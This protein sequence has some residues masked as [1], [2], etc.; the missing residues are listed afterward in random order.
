MA[1]HFEIDG[2]FKDDK[3]PFS[4]L[5]VKSTDDA[6]EDDDSI[7]YYGLSKEDLENSCEEDGLEF[8]VTHFEEIKF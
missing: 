1:Q 7:F 5:I 4:G 8:V 6:D 3:S 2:Y